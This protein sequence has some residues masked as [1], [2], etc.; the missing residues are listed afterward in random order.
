MFGI[1]DYGAFVVAIIIFLAI[2]GVGN[3]AIIT[4]T[5]KGGI[6]GGL[7]AT[8]GVIV[9]DQV[10]MWLAVAGVAAVPLLPPGHADHAPQ[11]ESDRVLHGVLSA[12]RRPGAPP[13]AR[14][15]RRDGAH[16]R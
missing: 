11:P 5:T 3:L 9:G 2:P 8:L 6:A 10:L 1:T 15:L 12:L 13:G 16:H 14:H 7:A 4:S